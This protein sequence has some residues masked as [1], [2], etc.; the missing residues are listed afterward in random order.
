MH[1]FGGMVKFAC[2]RRA[3][4]DLQRDRPTATLQFLRVLTGT[5]NLVNGSAPNIRDPVLAPTSPESTG[6]LLRGFP[7]TEGA[8]VTRIQSSRGSIGWQIEHVH[9]RSDDSFVGQ[10]ARIRQKQKLLSNAI[11]ADPASGWG[12][13]LQ[14]QRNLV[15]IL[16]A[17]PNILMSAWVT[18]AT[19][20]RFCA[21]QR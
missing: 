20:V 2:K 5:T 3:S 13:V 17:L 16:P 21:I 18:Q 15:L 19:A 9:Q 4:G 6:N 11:E 14:L 12:V 8:P 10:N 1:G 7:Q